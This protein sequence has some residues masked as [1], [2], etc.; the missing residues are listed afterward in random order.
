MDVMLLE[1]FLRVCELGSIN[2]AATSLGIS[3]STLSRHIATLEHEFRC[4][5]F[6]R[7]QGGVI[8]TDAGRLLADRARPLLRQFAMMKEQVSDQAAGQLAIGTPP[9]WQHLFTSPLVECLALEQPRIMLRIHEGLSNVLRDY[10][11]AGLL[12][13]AIIPFGMQSVMGYHKIS[14]LREPIFLV[15]GL[16]AGLSPEE[17]VG[18]E[19]LSAKELVLPGSPNVLRVRLERAMQRKG[20]RFQ[21]KAESDSLEL[22]LAL[23]KRGVGLTA[24]P[25][26]SLYDSVHAGQLSWAPI[27]GQHVAWSLCENVSRGHAQAVSEA[28]KIVFKVLSNALSMRKWEGAEPI[29][30]DVDWF[31][32]HA[33][34]R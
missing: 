28:K 27:K 8:L 20:V 23:A 25:A 7:T 14:I 10:M 1:V 9:A 32:K 5:A 3:Q 21:L 2:K 6:V 30:E 24:V 26:S 15:G 29:L 16:N 13:I 11:F 4:T 18:I 22:N 33:T 12:D 17:P 31:V 19:Y 34:G